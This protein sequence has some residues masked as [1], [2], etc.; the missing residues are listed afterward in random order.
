MARSLLKPSPAPPIYTY[1][2]YHCTYSLCL[3]SDESP[4][5]LLLPL[6]LSLFVLTKKIMKVTRS[7]NTED[8][9]LSPQEVKTINSIVSAR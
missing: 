6:S 4:P 3:E 2:H 1:T 8:G 5:P 9:N 7:V